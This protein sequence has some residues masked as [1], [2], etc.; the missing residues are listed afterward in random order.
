MR[1]HLFLFLFLLVASSR[2]LSGAVVIDPAYER[3]SEA[4]QT[5]DSAQRKK[6]FNDA[7]TLYLQSESEKSSGLFYYNIANTYFQLGEYGYAILYY[8]KAEKK[9]PRDSF[10]KN[11]LGVALEKAKVLEPSK[12][13]VQEYLFDPLLFFHT[14]FSHNEKIIISLLFLFL[15]FALYSLYIWSDQV[16]WFK[17]MALFFFFLVLIFVS[18]IAW[19][20]FLSTPEAVLIRPTLLRVDAGGQYAPVQN[21][22]VIPGMKV[23]IVTVEKNG[24]WLKV[25]L[26]SGAEGYIAKEYVRLI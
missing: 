18:S 6:L 12:T 22:A 5:K 2:V 17:K 9:L 23:K 1:R 25:L 26:P 13:I 24:T 19:A 16:R 20:E 15:A 3:Y 7:L 4:E 10:I 14:D 21:A 11:N 8:Y